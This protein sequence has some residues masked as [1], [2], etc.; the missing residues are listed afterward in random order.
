MPNQV[1]DKSDY[2]YVTDREG[3]KFFKDETRISAATWCASAPRFKL[4][5]LI[6]HLL[7]HG[8]IPQAPIKA[9]EKP[10]PKDIRRM[11]SG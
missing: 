7:L 1:T 10:S 6:D 2:W 8:A 9:A 4:E 5:L 11:N 3:L